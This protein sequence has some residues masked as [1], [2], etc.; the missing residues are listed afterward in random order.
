MD[1][2]RTEGKDI[3]EEKKKELLKK[4]EKA[5]PKLINKVSNKED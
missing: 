3:D 4:I 2:V 1:E 5:E